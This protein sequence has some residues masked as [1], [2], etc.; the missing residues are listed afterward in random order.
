MTNVFISGYPLKKSR[1]PACHA[2]NAEQHLLHFVDR[3]EGDIQANIIGLIYLQ[4]AQLLIEI[5]GN[6][7]V[8]K[9][10]TPARL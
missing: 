7:S 5:L 1:G 9:R 3:V 4:D 10:R 2:K 8:C 6:V